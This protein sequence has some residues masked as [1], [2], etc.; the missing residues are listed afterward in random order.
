MCVKE[1]FT[2]IVV[3]AQDCFRAVINQSSRWKGSNRGVWQ[4]TSF[5][6]SPRATQRHDSHI[7]GFQKFLPGVEICLSCFRKGTVFSLFAAPSGALS[8]APG[9]RS[10]LGICSMND[11]KFPSDTGVVFFVWHLSFLV[12]HMFMM[13][14]QIN[15]FALISVVLF[16]R[17]YFI[18]RLF[19]WNGNI[20]SLQWLLLGRDFGD[21]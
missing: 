20:S 16:K 2:F 12:F 9:T 1:Q 14:S 18:P 13:F 8:T 21:W 7:R 10:A 15:S 5:P 4:R 3:I 17:G 19:P 6:T 11:W